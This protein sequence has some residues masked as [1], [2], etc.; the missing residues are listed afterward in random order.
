MPPAR[1]AFAAFLLCLCALVFAAPTQEQVAQT[2]REL[3][4]AVTLQGLTRD[5]Q[6]L[7]KIGSRLAGSTGERRAL[8]YAERRFRTLGLQNIRR[9]PFYVTVPDPAARGSLSGNGWRTELLPLWPNLV[10]TATCDVSGPLVYG[11]DGSLERMSGRPIR[12]SIVLLEFNSGVGWRNAAKL[13]AAGIIFIEPPGTSRAEAEQK[14]GATPIDVPRFW[15][16]LRHAGPALSAAMEGQRA[17][18]QCRQDWVRRESFNLLADLPGTDRSAAREPLALM[19]YADSIGVVPGLAP[20]ASSLSGLAT[21]LQQAELW[22]KR[23]GRRPI[24]FIASG[25]HFQALQGA[26]EFAHRRLTTDRQPYLLGITLDLSGGSRAVGSYARGWFYEY[27]DEAHM[28]VQRMSRTLRSHAD[29]MHAD[30]GVQHPRLVLTDAA[31]NSDGRTWK[32]NIPGKFALDCEP[33]IQAGMNALT[34]TTIEDG[35][36]LLDTPFDTLD[37]LDVANVH[38]Q[39][40]TV[41][42][43]LHHVLND[44]SARGEISNYRV[45][46]EPTAPRA[47]HLTG[48]FA[49]IEGRIALF[50]PQE[51]F[52]PDVPVP[53]AMAAALHQ[54]KTMMGVRGAMLDLT[55]GADARY[56][57][58]GLSPI[59]AYWKTQIRNT[60]LAAFKLEPETGNIVYAPSQGLFGAFDYPISFHLKTAYKSSPIVVFPCEAINLFGLVDPQEL[61]AMQEFAVL[62]ATTDA[63]PERYGFIRAMVDTRLQSEVDDTAVFFA[64]PGHRFKL[65]GMNQIGETRLLLV[66]PTKEAPEGGG[67]QAPGEDSEGI[68]RHF[69]YLAL[70]A[71]KDLTALNG[72]R[73]SQFERYRIVSQG[74][75]RLHQDALAELREAED[76]EA[77]MDWAAAERH[78]RAAWSLALRAYPVV[79]KT[80]NDVVNGVIFYLFLIIPFS[81]F[82]ERLLFGNRALNRQLTIAAAIF[83]LTFLALYFIHPAFE[84]VANPSMIFVAF[85]MGAL[86]L[87]VITFIL[88][89]FEN[90]LKALKQEQSGVH[91]VDIGRMSVA[92]AAFNLG[93][94]NMRR[95]KAR[96]LLTT[97]TLVVMTFI[98]LSFTSI[99]S[100]LRLTEYPSDTPARYSGL[101]LRNPGL[102]PMENATFRTLANEFEGRG[103][104]ARRAYY[105]GA[106]IGDAG[107]LTL[108]RADRIS[109]VRAILGVDPEEAQVTRLHEALLPGGRW[110]EP[111]E[112]TAMI[113]PQRL[114]EHLRID[115]AIVGTATVQFAGIDYTVIGI[116]DES[117]LRA[118]T[119]LDGDG[120][121]PAD[122][123]LSRQFQ[124]ETGS[125]TQAFRSFIRL[126]PSV[127][128]LLPAETALGI[129]ADLRTLAVGLSDGQATRAALDELMP[130]LRLNLYASVPHEGG[131]QV[132]QFSVFQA[133]RGSGMGIILLQMLIASVFVLNTMVASVFERTKEISIFSAIGL[134]PNHIAML[135]F[136]ESLV[137]GI[138]GAVIG[139]VSAQTVAKIIVATGAFPGLYLNFSSLSAVLA[140]GLVML[141]V[142]ASTIYP[143][144]KASQIAAPALEDALFEQEP[145]TDE[146]IIPLPFSIGEPE[147]QPLIRFLGEWFAAYEEYT[148]GDFVTSGSKVERIEG[149]SGTTHQASAHAWIAPYDLGVSQSV[150]LRAAPGQVEGVYT[151]ELVLTRLS[152]EPS[153]WFNVNRRFLESLRKQFLT[154]RT[155]DAAQRAKYAEEPED[156]NAISATSG[157]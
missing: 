132:R 63:E 119:D 96:T 98:V 125:Q 28:R 3:D 34:F 124:T 149:D 17:R 56:R 141:V 73:V 122:F 105:Y 42:K 78:A 113:L 83:V 57:L 109:E 7:S 155:L 16:P 50:D 48:G 36:P 35:R 62:D 64:P 129:G 123:T 41:A 130:R 44:S 51:S 92:M 111:G 142:I 19:A 107:V 106:D 37:R 99:V 60:E 30:A 140:A 13:G 27:R 157:K 97:L 154:W 66:N 55:S 2:Y 143:A 118:L 134:A 10:R 75:E 84:I 31:N 93:I 150:V 156:Q 135:F 94:S 108:Q 85:V 72:Y 61:K 58:I 46:L 53:G 24:T 80:G 91:E 43:M 88:G 117:A 38:R 11:G 32:N 49:T 69:P 102:E 29:H 54:Q 110:F 18:L 21:L 22:T 120:I 112:R 89:K 133:A 9:E 144:R 138:L 45:P 145:E 79:Q 131:L 146:W 6:E 33:L 127:C 15:L 20:G 71:A 86:S 70:Q 153:N 67:Y 25:G 1:A 116:I 104:V 87:M 151:L 26:R 74:V 139:Y 82:M 5:L 52:V 12:G 100:D 14:F 40:Q 39:A 121:L 90:S 147:A 23:P 152:G 136:A 8:E 59:N 137:Y 128:F 114:A 76:A 95:R 101:L 148:I 4:R 47:M 103:A 81:Y 65:I 77:R 68:G 115:P 126:D